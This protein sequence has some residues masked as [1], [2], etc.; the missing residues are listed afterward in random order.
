MDLSVHSCFGPN[1]HA[2]RI[3]HRRKDPHIVFRPQS[4]ALMRPMPKESTL[5]PQSPNGPS[6]SCW[7]GK[8]C[9][10]IDAGSV[11]A[12]PPLAFIEQEIQAGL[13]GAIAKS[14]PSSLLTRTR[15]LG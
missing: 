1:S 5:S 11:G 12:T 2:F 9:F 4:P 6:A 15:K 14:K 3:R 7:R 13:K 8:F 10:R